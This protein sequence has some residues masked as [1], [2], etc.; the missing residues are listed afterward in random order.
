MWSYVDK[1]KKIT[2]ETRCGGG[3]GGADG[4]TILLS[5]TRFVPEKMQEGCCVVVLDGDLGSA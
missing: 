1:K 3:G 2:K 4:I 5:S